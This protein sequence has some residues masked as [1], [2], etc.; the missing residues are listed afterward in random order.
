MKKYALILREYPAAAVMCLA[1]DIFFT[2]KYASESSV[3]D[4]KPIAY[5]I[6]LYGTI[7]AVLIF[8]LGWEKAKCAAEK[9]LEE[10]RRYKRRQAISSLYSK[11]FYGITE[12]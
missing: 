12:K 6:A 2:V 4:P 9:K 1:A 8:T 11:E 3:S 10:R 7:M 5:F